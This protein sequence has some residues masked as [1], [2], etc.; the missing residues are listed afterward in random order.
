MLQVS[1]ETIWR[2]TRTKRIPFVQLANR[3]YRYVSN[4][5]LA[6]LGH[7]TNDNTA[8][9]HTALNP[10]DSSQ[11]IPQA[12]EA[13]EKYQ[14]GHIQICPD[15]ERLF[16][17]NDYL[18]LPDEECFSYEVLD[19]K[20]IREPAPTV[21]HQRVSRRLQFA[22][23][24]YLSAH[25]PEGEV[26]DAPIDVT[27]SDINVCRPDLIYISGKNRGIVEEK[28]I[29][30]APHLVVEILSP[31][32]RAKDRI[33]KRRIYERAEVPHY[34]IVDP[35]DKVMEAYALTNGAYVLRSSAC[36][37]EQFAHADFPGFTLSLTDLWKPHGF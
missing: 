7:I 4:D 3:K 8:P 17:Y 16:T 20:L 12:G 28:R 29:N 15:K 1:V 6:A 21:Q 25:D 24:S 13:E 10:I 5:V 32:T 27:L 11:P 34:W 37:D 36:E 2:Y 31:S 30:G 26:L 22:L 19:G 14:A 9:D 35:A 33:R 18:Q 23:I